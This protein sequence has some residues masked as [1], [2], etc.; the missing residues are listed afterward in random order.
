[1]TNR[2]LATSLLDLLGDRRNNT[3]VTIVAFLNSDQIDMACSQWRNDGDK[4]PT[5][6][7]WGKECKYL[8]WKWL[9]CR[10]HRVKECQ[11]RFCKC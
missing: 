4:I 10:T 11:K 9:G 5:Y 7:D 3:I 2:E 6:E 1:M 8:L